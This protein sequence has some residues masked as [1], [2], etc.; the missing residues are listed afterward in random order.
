MDELSQVQEE[1]VFSDDEIAEEE[2]LFD[3]STEDMP[4]EEETPQPEAEALPEEPFLK[5]T[6]DKQERGLT[7]DEAKDFAE[8]GMNYD[9]MRDKY[10]GLYGQLERLANLNS[11][12]VDDYLSRLNDTQ[13]DYMVNKEFKKL[14]DD[15]PND[16]DE[17]LQEIA[18]RRINESLTRRE[19]T[20][21]QREQGEADAQQAFI[22]QQIDKFMDEYPEFR[23]QGPE[24]LDPK[25]FEYAR[26]GYTLLEAYNKWSREQAEL[27]RPA[28]EAKAKISAKNEENRKKSLGNT[29]NAGKVESDDFLNGFLNG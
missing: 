15:Y 28:E 25:V 14:R 7:R 16:S 23:N 9:R 20:I 24:A 3:D 6:Y 4:V 19:Q 2:N 29:T 27:S 8:K 26:R 1:N 18:Q 13:F 17:V 22:Q 10:N 11:M 12:S 21:A 5:V